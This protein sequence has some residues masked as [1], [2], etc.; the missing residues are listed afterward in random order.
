MKSILATL[1]LA[2]FILSAAAFAADPAAKGA[3]GLLKKYA[4][5]SC[6][7]VDAK[8][9]GPSYKDVAKK[10]RKN[11]DAKQTLVGKVK[12]GGVGVWG[13]VP[14][15]PN[16]AVPDADLQAMIKWVLALK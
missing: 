10:Y 1:V 14:M 8:V 16:P 4:C 9:V 3:E 15:P 11:K 12:N 2:S 6:H 5:I 7:S 13:Q